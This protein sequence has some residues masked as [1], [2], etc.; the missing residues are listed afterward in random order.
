MITRIVIGR[1]KVF[2]PAFRPTRKPADSPRISVIDALAGGCAVKDIIRKVIDLIFGRIVISGIHEGPKV[3]SAKIFFTTVPKNIGIVCRTAGIQNPVN[4]IG[5]LFETINFPE[6][7]R[8]RDGMPVIGH[9]IKTGGCIDYKFSFRGK[10][11]AIAIILF[12]GTG[13]FF[14]ENL[15][16]WYAFGD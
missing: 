9:Y 2:I 10:F 5:S 11:P 14:F 6:T 12:S 13:F 8:N 16:G 15:P 7:G 4:M 3:G 1:I